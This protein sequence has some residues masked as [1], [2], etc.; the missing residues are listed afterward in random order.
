YV[1]SG[2]CRL[3]GL[4]TR[5]VGG[6]ISGS[7]ALPAT[8]AVF[9]RWTE[10]FLSGYGWFPADCS[11]D[12]NPIRGKRSHFGRVYVDAMVWCCQAGGEDDTLG[13]EY[14]AKV[15]VNGNDPGI[16]EN[17]RTRWFV[18]HPQEQV[19]AAYAWFSGDGE[20]L[21]EPDLL[22]CALLHWEKATLKNQLK[23]I[24]ALAAAGRNECL[25]RAAGL[26]EADGLRQ[27]CIR[28]LCESPELAETVLEESRHLYR[29]RSWFREN[30]SNLVPTPDGRFKLTKRAVSAQLELDDLRLRLKEYVNGLSTYIGNPSLTG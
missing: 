22:E 12:A 24:R 10:V 28:E 11:R 14:R 29:F 25:R 30:E 17:H 16:R 8:D 18:F 19:E 23:M 7:D 4:P 26:P 13:W 6:T 2:L 5:C 3:S 20:I 21:P 27:S 1:L 15:R 9:H